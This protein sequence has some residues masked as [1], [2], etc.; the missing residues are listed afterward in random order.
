MNLTP[1]SSIRY[2]GL[3]KPSAC[4]LTAADSLLSVT[5]SDFMAP[6]FKF[7]KFPPFFVFSLSLSFSNKQQFYGF[8]L[9]VH[10]FLLTFSCFLSH[11]FGMFIDISS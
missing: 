3:E 2:I 4:L 9:F 11:Y 5:N 10:F 8:H 1:R 7:T 6:I